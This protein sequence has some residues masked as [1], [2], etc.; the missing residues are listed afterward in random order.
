[1]AVDLTDS[2][3]IIEWD[4]NSNR[5]GIIYHGVE[6]DSG[7]GLKVKI[8]QNGSVPT[9]TTE[10]LRLYFNNNGQD[11]YINSR[12]TLVDGYY[13]IDLPTE[14]YAKVGN[15]S[16]TLRFGTDT[17]YLF[18]DMFDLPVGE[19]VSTDAAEASSQFSALEKALTTVD[20]YDTVIASKVA[21]TQYN[22]D[23]AC[24]NLKLAQKADTSLVSTKV[25]ATV[26][27]N[28]L[29]SIGSGTPIPYN[30]TFS[31]LQSDSGADHTKFYVVMATSDATYYKHLAYYNGSVW[32]DGGV[33]QNGT[34]N[35]D[36]IPTSAIS[37]I[38]YANDFTINTSYQ[39]DTNGVVSQESG[40]IKV[41]Y[42][43]AQTFGY[44]LLKYN[45]RRMTYKPLTQGAPFIPIFTV[46]S[47][48]SM[49]A[50]VMDSG[51]FFNLQNF[52]YSTGALTAG[53][54]ATAS[55]MGIATTYPSDLSY[56]VFDTYLD[57]TDRIDVG[58]VSTSGK[59]IMLQQLS[60]QSL[61]NT[62]YG[63]TAYS[64][65]AMLGMI[66]SYNRVNNGSPLAQVIVPYN[67]YDVND[68]IKENDLLKIKSRI[69][70]LETATNKKLSGKKIAIL[71]D[72]ITARPGASVWK[73]GIE[74]LTG[75]T[76]TMFGHSG[77]MIQGTSS[78]SLN[79]VYTEI[80]TDTDII[81]VEGGTNDWGNNGYLGTLNLQDFSTQGT[82]YGAL[83]ILFKGLQDRCPNA[84]IYVC[85]PPQRNFSG[86]GTTSGMGTNAN[87][88]TFEDC[89]TAIKTMANY[90]GFE[91]I[92]FYAN[93][94]WNI[95]NVASYTEDGLH[96]NSAGYMRM[97]DYTVKC[98]N[99]MSI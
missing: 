99:Q 41:T 46:A 26:F 71:G 93:L 76:V 52:N 45:K 31:A 9:I 15:T 51:S 88:M 49:H 78:L 67:L 86:T 13:I 57:Y 22:T 59:Y 90:F 66:T 98:I 62:R 65:T 83:N 1:M 20:Q 92:D 44:V 54:A 37:C 97:V 82:L 73:Q 58:Y 16:C 34:F 64:A 12:D 60:V 84:K 6:G 17:K 43:V 39:P 96:P 27:N 38:N 10:T 8:T 95:N 69:L 5:I 77:Q 48:Q 63:S 4:L 56:F 72:S 14:A 32:T 18:S 61:C 25:D 11:N 40:K 24:V 23:M 7:R 91:L 50:L 3:K 47:L 28:T 74:S 81:I 70:T 21:M 2:Y 94:G 85:T 53:T 33:Y 75:A 35:I 55:T 68:F 29:T 89:K 87:G 19:R 30:N 80:P 36:E 42:S 79:V